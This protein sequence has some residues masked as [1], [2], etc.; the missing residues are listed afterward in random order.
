VGAFEDHL[1][2][3][4]QGDPAGAV[5]QLTLLRTLYPWAKVLPAHISNLVYVSPFNGR[6][7]ARTTER[8]RA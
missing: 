8:S 7:P 4:G 2:A 3:V 1:V 5:R 6:S